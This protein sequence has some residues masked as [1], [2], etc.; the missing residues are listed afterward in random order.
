MM[1]FQYSEDRGFRRL[2]PKMPMRKP[3]NMIPLSAGEVTVWG[4]TLLAAGCAHHGPLVALFNK[5]QFLSALQ[6]G[7]P[8]VAYCRE[9]ETK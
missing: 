4:Q 2:E 1:G 9:Q 3:V 5:F 8:F 7:W 6:M